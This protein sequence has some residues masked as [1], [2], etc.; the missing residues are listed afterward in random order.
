MGLR[1]AVGTKA[2]KGSQGQERKGGV[3][4]E[5]NWAWFGSWGKSLVEMFEQISLRVRSQM[6]IRFYSS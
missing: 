4:P 1:N 2:Q 6:G 5:R 3:A